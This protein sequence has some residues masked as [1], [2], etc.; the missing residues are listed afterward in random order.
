[1]HYLD[2]DII[3]KLQ[4]R[5]VK[6]A[7]IGA[8]GNGCTMAVNLARINHMMELS[9]MQGLDVHIVDNKRISEAVLGRQLYSMNDIGRYKSAVLVEKI[10]RTYNTNFT[11]STDR[12]TFVPKEVDFI[13]SCVDN[14]STRHMISNS[15]FYKY[16]MDLGNDVTY[17]QVILGTKGDTKQPSV[18]G[19]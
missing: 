17:G 16:W 15:N 14:I 13:I 6:I 3:E 18:R 5:K 10:N 7:L 11:C 9:D 8:G 1:M 19:N 12:F 4:Y 2:S